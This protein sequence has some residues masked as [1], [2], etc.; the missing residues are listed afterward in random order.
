[1]EK[2]EKEVP[3]LWGDFFK[4]NTPKSDVSVTSPRRGYQPQILVF[5]LVLRCTYTV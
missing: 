5:V 3:Y 4:D 1:M 2:A